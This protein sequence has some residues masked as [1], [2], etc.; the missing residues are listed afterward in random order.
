MEEAVAMQKEQLIR[1]GDFLGP[2]GVSKDAPPP[3]MAPGPP[4]P[5]PPKPP[6]STASTIS[7]ANPAARKF[8]VDGTKL[9]DGISLVNAATQCFLLFVC[10]SQF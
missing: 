10:A 1:M 8:F 4:P 9:P 3:P 2:L 7:F 5:V 6:G